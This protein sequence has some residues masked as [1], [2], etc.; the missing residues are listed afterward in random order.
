M[1][2]K[3]QMILNEINILKKISKGHKNVITLYDYFETPNNL[4]D[5]CIGG[6]LFDRIIE[7]GQFY[8]KDAAKIIKAVVDALRYLHQ[9]NIPENLLFK[10]KEHDSDIVVA[11]FGLAVILEHPDQKYGTR[12]SCG[13]PEMILK[14]GH[15]KPV[16]LWALGVMAFFL[17]S[18]C[19]PFENEDEIMEKH[20]NC[21][22]IYTFEPT[23]WG[24]V[25][26]NA[27]DFIQKLIVV[28]EQQRLTAEQAF[29][30]KWLCDEAG[31]HHGVEDLLPRVRKGFDARKMFKKAIDVVKAVNK[32]SMH[33]IYSA[34]SSGHS[35]RSDIAREEGY[36]PTEKS[37]LN[38]PGF[39]S[40]EGS[41]K[42]TSEPITVTLK[43]VPDNK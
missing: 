17:L 36:S 21:N 6:E 40:R 34:K 26:S 39:I 13:T 5:L 31:E 37:F 12:T 28:D 10:N 4:L 24:G 23:I 9:N 14:L 30:H 22:A 8:E 19:L 42:D 7:R 25:S 41:F 15:G 11:D 38:V 1:R 43:V 27:K 20:N 16:D 33:N 2:G 29:H 18:G 35:S 3:E 32:L